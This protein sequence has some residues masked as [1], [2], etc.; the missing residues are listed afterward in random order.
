M[1][2]KLEPKTLTALVTGA[3][4]GIGAETAVKLGEAGAYTLIHYNRAAVAAEG[5]LCRVRDAGGDGALLQADLT[6]MDGV[7]N[8]IEQVRQTERSVDIL[9]NNAGSL[10]RRT[11]VLD[12]TEELWDQV[13]TLNLKSAFFLAQEFLAGM[14]QRGHGVLVN[15]SSVAARNGGGIGALAYAA[16]KGAIYSMTR[17][18]AKEFGPKGVRVNAVSPGTVGTNYHRNFS[19]PQGLQAVAA[20]TPLGR[21]GKPEEVADAI[22]Y[23]C[24]P[25]SS[26]LEGEIIEINGGHFMG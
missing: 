6:S 26:F 8:L 18:L 12:F 15:V 10:I 16:S 25:G 21:I 24:S 20:S 2:W 19:T 1:Q 9:I 11:P 3:S 23:L 13:M 17:A 22:L 14:E 7:R 5:V 4:S